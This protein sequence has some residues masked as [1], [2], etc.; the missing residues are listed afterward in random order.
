M[1]TLLEN[2]SLIQDLKTGISD[3]EARLAQSRF[4]RE[5]TSNK[6]LAE[7][8]AQKKQALEEGRVR[9]RKEI[10]EEQLVLK[11]KQRQDRLDAMVLAHER[12][13]HE[14][15]A[16]SYTHVKLPTKA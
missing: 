12:L 1:E 5:H 13:G 15:E 14:V 11:E 8:L 7:E 4:G 3:V 10:R 9:R 16:V 6:V 2:D